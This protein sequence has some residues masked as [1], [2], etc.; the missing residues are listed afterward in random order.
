MPRCLFFALSLALFAQNKPETTSLLGKPLTADADSEGRIAKADAA[1]AAN[2]KDID[3]ILAAGAAR[4]AVRQY[5]AAIAVYSKGLELEPNNAR[6]LRVRGHR[7]I[8]LRQFD[9][10]I[11][12]LEKARSQAPSAF[13]VSYYLGLALYLKGS[14]NDSANEFARCV[15]MVGKPDE[16]AKTLP[17]GM[18]S[19]A[20][21][22]RYPDFLIPLA[23]WHYRSLRRAGRHGEAKEILD[24]IKPGMSLQ[25]NRSNYDALM[26][27]KGLAKEAS[28]LDGAEGVAFTNLASGIGLFQVLEGKASSGCG[29]LRKAANDPNWPAFGVIAAEAEL[30]RHA[31]AAC[32]LFTK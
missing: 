27:Y 25:Q 6:L 14:F 18:R 28:V 12:D 5:N 15:N 8:S 24:R 26:V 10:A 16:F 9:P 4:D 21:L 3:L 11:A 29:L 30:T 19:C 7:R 32:A 2:P 22:A 1:L 13:E 20:D 17:K 31:K 23:D